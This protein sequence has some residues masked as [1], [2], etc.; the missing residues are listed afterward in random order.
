MFFSV[1]VPIYKVEKYL[2]RCV[3]SVLSQTFD[4][5]ELLRIGIYFSEALEFLFDK[6]LALNDIFASSFS[7][8][9]LTDL[10]FRFAGHNSVEPIGSRFL[11]R[12]SQN[13]HLVTIMQ[14]LANADILVANAT[15]H[16]LATHIAM[17]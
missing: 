1:V 17:Y 2:A 11:V 14:L 10:V 6:C 5:F 9:P 16:T 7:L 3:D 12:R 4:D 8:I 13:L 15:T